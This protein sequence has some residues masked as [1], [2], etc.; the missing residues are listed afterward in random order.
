MSTL[1]ALQ[2]K[3]TDLLDAI[4]SLNPMR[5]GSV[6]AQFPTTKHKDGTTSKRG[7]YTMYTRKKNGKPV[8]KRLSQKE[9]PLYRDQVD[10]FREF[11]G[12]SAKFVE[13]SESLAD[14][15]VAAEKEG[16]KN[17]RA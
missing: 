7:P 5:M 14:L 11:Q 3:K 6:C 4:A 13:T 10:Q 8:G 16:K 9:A 2:Q 12:L 17:S 1:K 15:E